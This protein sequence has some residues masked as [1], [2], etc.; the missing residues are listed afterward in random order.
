MFRLYPRLEKSAAD[1]LAND[2]FRKELDALSSAS[3]HYHPQAPTA[4]TG[5]TPITRSEL[6]TLR[7]DVVTFVQSLGFPEESSPETRRTFDVEIGKLY[8]RKFIHLC[9]C[10]VV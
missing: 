6:E 8:T 9:A 7:N 2:Y 4:E 10:R 1:A 3:G 5:G